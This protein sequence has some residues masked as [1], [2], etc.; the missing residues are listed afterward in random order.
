MLRRLKNLWRLSQYQV[1]ND[2]LYHSDLTIS[3]SN[4]LKLDDK[5]YPKRLA[6]IVEDKIDLFPNQEP[7]GETTE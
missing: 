5:L 7:D 2:I 3:Q 4:E 6:T 1:K